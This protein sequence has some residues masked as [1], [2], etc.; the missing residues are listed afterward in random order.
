MSVFR[1]LDLF[2]AEALVVVSGDAVTYLP[3]PATK[4]SSS[5]PSSSSSFGGVSE[6]AEAEAR[7][8][9]WLLAHATKPRTRSALLL[10][11]A[12]LALVSV[13]VDAT[14][15][16]DALVRAGNITVHVDTNAASSSSSYGSSS[17][18]SS[19]VF[20]F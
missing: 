10:A 1:L 15:V 20:R 4:S 13:R 19:L 5:Y 6:R 12:Q 9:R 8:R 7:G 17:S 2:V 18:S 14:R 3:P 16:L 11:L